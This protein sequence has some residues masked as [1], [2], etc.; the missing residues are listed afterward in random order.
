MDLTTISKIILTEIDKCLKNSKLSYGSLC[1]ET[2]RGMVMEEFGAE[3][4]SGVLRSFLENPKESYDKLVKALG[5]FESSAKVLITCIV[6]ELVRRYS[7]GFNALVVVRAVKTGDRSTLLSC[8]EAL[9]KA[10]IEA[11]KGSL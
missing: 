10:I 5:G 1:R 8:V 6:E 4:L 7:P 11:K 3:D 9:L 2:L